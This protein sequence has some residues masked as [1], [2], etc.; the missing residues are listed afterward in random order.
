MPGPAEWITVPQ[1]AKLL[2]LEPH[3]VYALIHRG[4]LGAVEMIAPGPKRRRQLR[5]QRAAVDHCVDRARIK[6]GSLRHLY[7]P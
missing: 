7:G 1:V 5:V 6:P 3:T 4:E 2:G